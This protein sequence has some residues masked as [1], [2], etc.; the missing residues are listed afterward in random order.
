VI[1]EGEGCV[2]VDLRSLEVDRP[3]LPHAFDAQP[4]LA[5]RPE[6]YM[7]TTN[8]SR[9]ISREAKWLGDG[10]IAVTGSDTWTSRGFDR[11]APAG[12]KILNVVRCT[13]RP[14]DRRAVHLP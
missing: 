2:R 11:T 10:K 14:V 7:G 4:E 3:R 13:V 6:E 12:L 1:G 9:H 5:S 8:P